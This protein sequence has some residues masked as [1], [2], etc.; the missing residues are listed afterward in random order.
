MQQERE[1]STEGGNDNNSGHKRHKHIHL[2]FPVITAPSWTVQGA[3]NFNA[4][5]DAVAKNEE[6]QA[7][8][9]KKA[10]VVDVEVRDL[11][12]KMGARKEAKLQNVKTTPAPGMQCAVM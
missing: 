11:K 1:G 12:R 5:I 3:N 9:S 10:V 2:L 8:A 7:G 6:A 4:W